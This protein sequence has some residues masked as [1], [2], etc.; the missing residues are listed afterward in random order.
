M[1]EPGLVASYITLAGSGFTEPPRYTFRERCEAASAAGFT[2][3]GIHVTDLDVLTPLDVEQI[4]AD[5]GLVLREIEF[6]A[7]WINPDDG[8]NAQ[9]TMQ[10][11]AALAER[12]GGD[13]VSAGDFS[14][15]ALD[16]KAAAQRLIQLANT[17]H[18]VGLRIALEAFAWSAVNTVE[19]AD[20]LLCQADTPAVG[21][22]LDV[23]HFFNTGADLGTLQHLPAQRI[24]A[25]QLN[26]G[27]RVYNDFLWNA[28]NTRYLP[29]DGELE[30][31]GFLDT[32]AGIGYTGPYCVEVNYPEFRTYSVADAAKRAYDATAS[33]FT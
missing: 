6:L 8:A 32:L 31:R 19:K 4:L 21:H 24:A 18:G 12:V 7:G 23:W 11:V 22:L 5:T 13:H 3:I 14:G 17:A 28:R 15:A 1:T 20:A 25:V 27:P 29:G 30:V 16:M 26:D 9:A 33:Y 10:R 2:G